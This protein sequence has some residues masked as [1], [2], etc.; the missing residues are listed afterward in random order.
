MGWREE[1]SPLPNACAKP[2]EQKD[3]FFLVSL[4]WCLVTLLSPCTYYSEVTVLCWHC[5]NCHSGDST[6]WVK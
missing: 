5:H 2:S 1:G 3:R 4:Y 6:S